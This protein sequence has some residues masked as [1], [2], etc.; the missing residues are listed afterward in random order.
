MIANCLHCGDPF[1]R[2]NNRQFCSPAHRIL[3]HAGVTRK[4]Y[5]GAGGPVPTYSGIPHIEDG[6]V[7][8]REELAEIS[9]KVAYAIEDLVHICGNNS[10]EV[11]VWRKRYAAV[12]AKLRELPLLPDSNTQCITVDMPWGIRTLSGVR[13]C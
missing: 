3:H 11:I 13:V 1:T 10:D 6:K 12:S 2:N 7:Y 4:H 9:R 5:R 8:S